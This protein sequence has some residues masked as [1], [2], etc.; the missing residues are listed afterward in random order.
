M[1]NRQSAIEFFNQAATA[2]NDKS[3]P[4]NL[5]IAYQLFSA[6]CAADPTWWN[7]WYQY[8][9]N[10]FDLKRYQAAIASYYRSLACRIEKEDRAKVL[11]NLGWALHTVGRIE[12]A[13]DVLH[14]ALQIDNKSAE[15]WVN[16]ANVYGI[17]DQP[18]KAVEAARNG[19]RLKPDPTSEIVY[20]FALL[21]NRQLAEGFKHFE[22]RFAW[23][24]HSFLQYPYPKWQGESGK[25]VFMVADQGLG[26]TIS[27]SRFV[28]L[29]AKRARFIHAYVQPELMRLFAHAFIDIPNINLMPFGGPSFPEADAWTTFVSLPF[30][31][32]LTDDEIRNTPQIKPYAEHRPTSWMIPDQ[33][34]HVGVAWAG[35]KLN[36]I[37]QHR[38]IP[39]EQFFELARIPGVQLYSLQVGEHAEDAN[40]AGGVAL[41]RNLV[42]YI[43]DVV[44]TLSLLRDLDLVI[45]CESALGHIC[46][47]AGKECWVPYSYLGRDYRIGHSDVDLLWTPKHKIFWQGKEQNW[48][49]AF[50]KIGGL[51]KERVAVLSEGNKHAKIAS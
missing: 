3:S 2:A 26:D 8:G 12:E 34:L 29:A 32:G 6:A 21:F 10:Q 51:L 38:S 33:K 25:T 35:S 24:L 37:N 30:A 48:F 1:G 13:F 47:L 7:A 50:T 22:A 27:F 40:N 41:I 4:Q 42:P 49:P 23:K 45:T 18:A 31:L 39:V 17:L 44:D 43:R 14:Q 19:Y 15:T 46:A 20:A 5:T 11:C 16:L 36:E 9:N 28:H